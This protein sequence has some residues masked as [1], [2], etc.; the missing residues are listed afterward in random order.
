MPARARAKASFLSAI[1]T[2][3][4]IGPADGTL[5]DI[6]GLVGADA[7]SFTSV[8]GYTTQMDISGNKQ[9]IRTS[10]QGTTMTVNVMAASTGASTLLTLLKKQENGSIGFLKCVVSNGSIGTF[11]GEGG[12]ITEWPPA[13]AI[14]DGAVGDM[15]YIITW[16]TYSNNNDSVGAVGI[17]QA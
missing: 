3:F 10:E 11:T 17:V 8:P 1:D 12:V 7:I 6:E 5:E 2:T 16:T 15:A 13:P 14:G 9:F 4:R